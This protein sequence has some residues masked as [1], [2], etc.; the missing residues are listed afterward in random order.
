MTG[1]ADGCSAVNFKGAR[2]FSQPGQNYYALV[3]GDFNS[4]GKPDLAAADYSANAVKLSFGNGSGSFLNTTSTAVGV[5]PSYI[6]AGDMNN[7]GKLDLVTSNAMSNDVSVLLNNGAGV[8]TVTSYGAGVGPGGVVLADFNSDGK[9]DVAATNQTGGAVVILLNNG[10][11]GLLPLSFVTIPGAGPR[12]LAAGDFNTDGK[13]DLAVVS[14]PGGLHLLLGTGTGTFATPQFITTNA[15]SQAVT[16]GDFTGD[17]KLD[18]VAVDYT[19]KI[20]TVIPGTGTGTFLSPTNY[21]TGGNASDV[22]LRDINLDGKLDIIVA[23]YFTDTPAT[24]L[25][26]F[27]GN[28]T[29]GVSTTQDVVAGYYSRG[30]TAGDFNSDGKPDVVTIYSDLFGSGVSIALNDGTGKLETAMSTGAVA[31]FALLYDVNADGKLDLLTISFN[32]LQVR[33]GLGDSGGNFAA[34]TTFAT[35]AGIHLAVGDFNGDGRPD[36]AAAN[37]NNVAVLLNTGGGNFSAPVYYGN[38]SNVAGLVTGDYTGDGKLD[39]VVASF[40]DRT[41]KFFTGNGVG[42]FL[43]TGVTNLGANPATILSGDFNNDGKLDVVTANECSGPSCTSKVLTLLLGNGMGGFGTPVDIADA[44]A[45]NFIVLNP[46]LA[47]A[48]DFNGDGRLDL[49]YTGFGSVF[50]GRVVAYNTGG[51]SFTASV[52]LLSSGDTGTTAVADINSDGKPDIVLTGGGYSR[53]LKIYLNNGNDFDP[54]VIYTGAGD[55]TIAIGDINADGKRDILFGNS[56]GGLFKIFNKC[57][58]TRGQ[59]TTDFDGDGITDLSVFR[60]ST[61]NW[62]II[63]SSDNSFHAIP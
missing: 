23:N 29:G 50:T 24:P 56:G 47:A 42:A 32:G 28:G 38:G 7:D 22:E 52:A 33:L 31:E 48:G 39:I 53:E 1:Y 25:R 14:N 62:Y 44:A 59:A 10:S 60:P 5:H 34:P 27:Y 18:V 11:G 16:A 15:G 54:P 41:V 26:I 3:T 46:Q 51:A 58:L 13:A 2:D 55:R 45:P 36:I 12:D 4:D 40:G 49:T 35:V 30:V 19:A 63:Y 8:F 37:G 17:G 61:G 20:A 9:L 21:A 6:A 57:A 43:L